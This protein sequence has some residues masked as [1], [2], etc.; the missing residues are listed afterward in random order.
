MNGFGRKE[1]SLK[2]RILLQ[3]LRYALAGLFFYIA[4]LGFTWR[5]NPPAPAPPPGRQAPAVKPPAPA[6]GAPQEGR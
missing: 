2:M 3:V 5:Y 6:P 4:Y 1:P